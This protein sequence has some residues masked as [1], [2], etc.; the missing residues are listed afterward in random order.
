MNTKQSKNINRLMKCF[1]YMNHA[2]QYGDIHCK[3]ILKNEIKRIKEKILF[4]D[5][6][7]DKKNE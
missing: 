7:G 3:V 2:R 5:S 6:I 1:H 4:Y